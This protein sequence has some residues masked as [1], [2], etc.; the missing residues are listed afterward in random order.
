MQLAIQR[1]VAVRELAD[2][3][4]DK[5]YIYVGILHYHVSLV[6]VLAPG[7][8]YHLNLGYFGPR[9]QTGL[10]AL[11]MELVGILFLLIR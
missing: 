4:R 1:I 10:Y 3:V 9:N 11:L 5:V 7:T 2:V 6:V 8:A